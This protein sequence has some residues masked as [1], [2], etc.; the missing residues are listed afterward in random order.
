MDVRVGCTIALESPLVRSSGVGL[1]FGT[2]VLSC[3]LPKPHCP[4]LG[5]A[6]LPLPSPLF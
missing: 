1:G 5:K 4:R 6:S 2:L 3:G